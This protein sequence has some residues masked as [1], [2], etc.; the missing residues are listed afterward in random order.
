MLKNEF[1]ATQK[2][3]CPNCNAENLR[4]Q[5][6]AIECRECT[7]RYVL[8]NG[9]PVFRDGQ[10][11]FN[12][13]VTLETLET[14]TS[15]VEEIGWHDAMID[16]MSNTPLKEA[17]LIWNRTLG[18]HRL[19]MNM[20]LPLSPQAK[21]LDVGSGWGTVSMNMSRY[22]DQ[23]VSMDQLYEHLE[24]QRVACKAKGIDN[25]TFVQGGDTNFL[26]FPSATFDVAIMNGVLEWVATNSTGKPRDVQQNFLREISRVLKPSGALYIGIENRWNH[27]YFRGGK[28]GHIRMK[29]GALLPRFITDLYLRISRGVRYREYTYTLFGYRKL[30]K[31]AGL[32]NRRFYAPWPHYGRIVDVLPLVKEGDDVPNT[33]RVQTR[34][35]FARRPYTYFSHTY[36][37]TATPATHCNGI[38]DNII[39]QIALQLN[40]TI[41]VKLSDVLFRV[42]SS[43][44]AVIKALGDAGE[45]YHV[46]IDVIKE[47]RE[48]IK[49]HHG[50]LSHLLQR[51]LGAEFESLLPY[52]LL[53]GEMGGFV[54]YVEPYYEGLSGEEMIADADQ[55]AKIC[56]HAFKFIT[57]LSLRTGKKVRIDEEVFQ[58][59]FSE[60]MHS[61]KNWFTEREWIILGP[62]MASVESAMWQRVA[63]KEILLTPTHGDFVP[64][65]CLIDGDEKLYKILDWELYEADGLP[66]HDW[67]TFLGRAHKPRI[68]KE[69]QN[70]GEDTNAIRFHG[71]PQDF[72]GDPLRPELIKYVEKLGIDERLLNPLLF[73]WWVK[74]LRDWEHIFLYHP[75]WRR[76]RVYPLIE[77]MKYL[78]EFI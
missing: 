8:R 20:L 63:N 34:R 27:K 28:E 59:H 75:E 31:D 67:I 41:P 76:L 9:I 7:E 24:W 1:L 33:L 39:H 43:G 40:W 72:T 16:L 54:Y 66:L 45:G 32:R 5:Q 2:Y 22:C 30:L 70:R 58:A 60:P 23:L 29:Y 47:A 4:L 64:S 49:N 68:V 14:V 42:R 10:A 36:A 52:P 37:M 53:L 13:G 73:M 46:R 3:A 15:S 69:M 51:N 35:R 77:R 6:S 78:T 21:V 50:T 55:R 56:S 18:H 11:H 62:W 57:E 12:W 44:K 74:Q 61:I 65:N 38:L 71:Y 25:I 48:G 19:A 17:Q 26:P